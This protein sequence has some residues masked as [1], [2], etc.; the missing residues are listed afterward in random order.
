MGE[1]AAAF[2]SR[3][4]VK[5][6]REIVA[7]V[8]SQPAEVLAEGNPPKK[9][10]EFAGRMSSGSDEISIAL[11]RSPGGWSEP[12]QTPGFTEYSVV[13][14]GM[15]RATTRDG[16]HDIRPGQAIVVESG[17]WVQYSTPLPEGAEYL[18][19]CRPAFSPDTVHR[20]G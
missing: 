5:T 1:R 13:L 7:R 12:G 3:R 16:T 18:A 15:L 4:L 6:G 19:V 8:I 14:E 9:I 17:E 2:I 20:D 10:R 11:M